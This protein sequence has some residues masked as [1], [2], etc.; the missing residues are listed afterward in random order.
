[1][2]PVRLVELL[3]QPELAPKLGSG[4]WELII[5]QARAAGLLARLAA[6]LDGCDRLR[7]VPMAPRQYLDSALVIARNHAATMR[8]EVAAIE[9][10]LR[11]LDLPVVLLKGGAYLIASL[12]VSQGRFL[13]T[14]TFWCLVTA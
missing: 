6:L 12:P 3:R 10:A 5:P 4:D 7:E 8:W 11:S 2:K 9:E 1:M 13:P 14:W